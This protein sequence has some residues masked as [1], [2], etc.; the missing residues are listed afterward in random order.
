M[1]LNKAILQAQEDLVSLQDRWI[2]LHGSWVRGEATKRSDIDVAIITGIHDR[3]A[4]LKDFWN[5]IA[6]VNRSP[7]DIRIFELLPLHIQIRIIRGYAVVFGNPL[8]IS[9]YFY[10]YRKLWKDIE[11][12]YM[13]NQ[14]R[15]VQEKK[16]A[17]RR[18]K[19]MISK[20]E[21]NA[22]E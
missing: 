6:G 14:F 5:S 15:S 11:P 8:E 3:E 20:K 13:Q 10:F 22:R 9:E 1:S 21:Y 16:S 12:R 18:W 4:L 17:I 7:Y 19:T 2:V